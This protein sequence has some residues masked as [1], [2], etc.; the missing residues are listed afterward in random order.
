VVIIWAAIIFAVVCAIGVWQQ[1]EV[2]KSIR[3]EKG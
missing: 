1:K 3:R 2:N